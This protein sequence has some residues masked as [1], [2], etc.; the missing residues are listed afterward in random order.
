[1]AEAWPFQLIDILT[2]E[3]TD[4]NPE[5]KADITFK[6]YPQLMDILTEAETEISVQNQ[7]QT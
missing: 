4:L 5:P 6:T 1:M 7:K 3:E 2:D